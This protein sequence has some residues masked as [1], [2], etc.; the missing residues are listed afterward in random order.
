[1][2]VVVVVV[3]L[4]V[5]VVNDDDGLISVV[6][7]LT[8]LL[9]GSLLSLSFWLLVLFSFSSVVIDVDAGIFSPPCVLQCGWTAGAEDGLS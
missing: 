1:M 4:V 7:A 5:V 8:S 3:V 2:V 6:L 9:S